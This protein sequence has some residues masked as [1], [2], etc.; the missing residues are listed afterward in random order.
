MDHSEEDWS[1]LVHLNVAFQDWSSNFPEINLPKKKMIYVILVTGTRTLTSVTFQW[2]HRIVEK[3]YRV[4]NFDLG[5]CLHLCE[6]TQAVTLQ[7]CNPSS[8]AR[9]GSTELSFYISFV[10]SLWN[11]CISCAVPGSPYFRALCSQKWQDC[12]S[13]QWGPELATD[14]APWLD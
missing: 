14:W 3:F 8:P 10:L 9:K 13:C 6:L 7:Q 5:C 11:C 4:R 2:L 1:L 12:Q